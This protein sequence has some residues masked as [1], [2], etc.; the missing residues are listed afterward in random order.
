MDKPPFVTRHMPSLARRLTVG[1]LVLGMCL[2]SVGCSGQ[3][4][5]PDG[6][7]VNAD[8][9]EITGRTD[10]ERPSG[11][12]DALESGTTGI[13]SG[14]TANPAV[15][16]PFLDDTQAMYA[17][18]LNT[19]K[20]DAILI[21]LVERGETDRQTVILLDTGDADDY[22]LIAE[23]LTLA[24]VDTIDYMILSHMDN[25]HIGSADRLL[26]TFAVKEVYMPD[27]VRQSSRYRALAEALTAVAD[28]TVVHRLQGENVRL[29]L[30]GAQVWINASSLYER[31]LVVNSDN[32]TNLPS[33][34]N[35]FSLITSVYCGAS[36]LFLPGDAERERM[37]EFN[38]LH[39]EATYTL[40]K[41]PHHGSSDKALEAFVKAAGLSYAVMTADSA[42]SVDA[43][44]S[45]LLRL[46][47]VE[48]CHTYDGDVLFA[49]NGTETVFRQ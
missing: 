40:I 41:T 25:D 43:T 6:T 8:G 9:G 27:Y 17:E 42:D 2:L 34:E 16:L 11:V 22:D 19:G 26:R 18:F 13:E 20:S 31:G 28:Q 12:G 45:L 30:G 47:N 21:R 23:R 44:L 36:S 37:E 48:L 29:D 24:G 39:D 14:T 49:T 4:L 10:G 1:L 38:A 15:P 32:D 46:C 5:M 33:D 3:I 7:I 35:N